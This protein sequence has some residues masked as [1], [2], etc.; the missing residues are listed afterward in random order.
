MAAHPPTNRFKAFIDSEAASALP[1]L[2]AAILAL[3]LANSPLREAVQALLGTKVGYELQ[4]FGVY[5]PLLLWINDGLMAVFFLLVGLEIKREVV[6]GELSR[7]SQVALPIAGAV[8][9]MVVPAAIYAA[10]NWS[11]PVALRGWAIPAATDIAF[12][13]GVLAALGSRVPLALK[14]FLTTLAIVDDLGAI[15]VIAVFYTS[16]LS[17]LSIVAAA[18]CLLVLAGLNRLGIRRLAPYILIGAVLW[19]AVLKSGVHATL[20]GVALAM[21]IPLK[22]AGEADG[23]RPA[24]W[25]EHVLKPW[26]AWFI[27]PV[28]AFANAGLPLA[29]LSLSA[30]A[31]P[32][33]LGILAGLFIGKQV[34]I[35]LGA[36][37]LIAL[38]LASMPAGGSWRSLYG[39]SILG[40]IGF[41]MSLFIG[42]LAFPDPQFESQVRLGVLAG[43]LLSAIVGYLILRLGPR[44]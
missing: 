3:V 41:T 25:L 4:G 7:P 13:L 18:F 20:A 42:T 2:A 26:S 15:L 6:E 22:S 38:G 30:L 14:V 27:M 10:L 43:S 29:G 44:P 12:S 8:G 40:G 39:V 5:K 17:M 11:D 31:A 33:P 9:G 23:A 35:V 16:D 36:G 28:F 21:F 34:G 32:I 1:L 19:V 24:I 37:L